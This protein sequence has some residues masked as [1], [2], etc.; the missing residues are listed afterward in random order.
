MLNVVIKYILVFY[1][2]LLR[3]TCNV[4]LRYAEGAKQ[5]LCEGGQGVFPCWHSRF[6]MLLVIKEIGKFQAVA[7]THKD[8]NH[9]N[10]VLHYLGHTVIRGSSRRGGFSAMKAILAIKRHEMR[11]V[12]TPDGPIGPRFK[13]KG[14][15]L[16]IA[17]RYNLPILPISYS[18]TH[19]LVLPTWDNFIIP[20]P[21]ISKI[22]VDFAAPINSASIKD[23]L[24]LEKILLLQV[25]SL[26]AL[27]NIYD[28]I[29]YNL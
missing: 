18:A 10:E 27:C 17:Q 1:L 7:S 8:A 20:I 12:V 28:K 15:V 5:L 4:E 6:L 19:A 16:K 25:Q 24:E 21:F 14:G 23:E 22:K 9:L 26:D 13:V 29:N 2:W 11:L 3:N